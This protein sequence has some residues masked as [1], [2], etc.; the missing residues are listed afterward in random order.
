MGANRATGWAYREQIGP[1]TAGQTVLAHLATTYAHSSP[2]EWSKR[3]LRGEV[4]L[5]GVV[6]AAA[7][8]LE[9]AQILVWHRPAWEEPPVPLHYDV[10]YEDAVIVAVGKPSG[11]P[12]MPAGGYL[13]HTLLALVRKRYADARPVHRLGRHTSGVVLF[14]RTREA[15]AALAQAWRQRN[16]TK[17]YLALASGVATADRLEVTAPIGPVPHRLLGSVHAVS[18]TGK[19]ARSLAVVLERRADSTLFRVDLITGRPHQIRIHLAYAGYPLTGDRLYGIGGLPR[20]GGAALPGDGGYLLHAERLLFLHP[21]L[22]THM[23]IES[24]PPVELQP[25]IVS[26]AGMR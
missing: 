13:H 15:A 9:A 21:S 17:R 23:D 6:V 20:A 2:D 11:L 25:T 19:P 4:E 26:G 16:V 18:S 7:T 14:A 12:T 8:V 3:L 22:Q 24:L 10:L 5:D 1:K